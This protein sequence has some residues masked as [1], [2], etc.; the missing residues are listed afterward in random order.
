M[1]F[2]VFDI[3]FW[4]RLRFGIWFSCWFSR[5]LLRRSIRLVRHPVLDKAMVSCPMTYPPA[6]LTRFSSI[7]IGPSGPG[8]I[9]SRVRI[10]AARR[11]VADP[12]TLWARL[13]LVLW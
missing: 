1:R 7:P 9:F 3:I 8:S 11:S 10:W 12:L 6:L 4:G 5:R 13:P 2:C